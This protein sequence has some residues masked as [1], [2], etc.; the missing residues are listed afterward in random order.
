VV[1]RPELDTER[2]GGAW[3]RRARFIGDAG[4]SGGQAAGGIT[5]WQGV[6]AWGQRG[7]RAPQRGRHGPVRGACGCR[8]HRQRMT[9]AETGGGGG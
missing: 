3:Q 2:K 9:S 1:R 8:M 5:W 7:G 4:G 6:G